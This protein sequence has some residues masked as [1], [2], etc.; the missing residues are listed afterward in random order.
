MTSV[1]F[2]PKQVS[3]RLFTVLPK[4]ARDVLSKRFGLENEKK[5]T[6][7]SIG[8]MYGITRE[9]VRQIENFALNTVRKSELFDKERPVFD[10]LEN[11]IV[12]LGGVI[13]E[14]DLLAHLAKDKQTQNHIQ[15]F[16]VLG[17]Q[18]TRQREDE[19]FKHRWIVDEPLADKVHTA[20]KKLYANLSD[21]DLVSENE[22]TAQFLG[23]L[24]D[25]AERYKNEEVAKRWLIL[26]DA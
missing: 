24:K 26:Y 23:H 16:L 18:F 1:S 9:R 4:R 14:E 8:S 22:I 6:L 5:M 15:L 13:S 21:E 25:A 11:T 20:L 7:E 12:S 3:K 19:H 2:K 10:E 17:D